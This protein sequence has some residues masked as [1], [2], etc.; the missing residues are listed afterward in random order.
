MSRNFVTK[1]DINVRVLKLKTEIIDKKYKEE[2]EE[3]EEGAPLQTY[4]H[5]GAA[6]G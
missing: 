2:S 6:G 4:H 5:E 3:W 1:E